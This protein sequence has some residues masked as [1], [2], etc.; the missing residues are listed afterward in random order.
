MDI[1]DAA[2]QQFG[3]ERDTAKRM[4][5]GIL[6]GMQPK[7]LAGHMRWDIDEAKR[8]HSKFLM[9][10][11]PK[12]GEFQGAAKRAFLER[13]YV[14]SVLGRKARLDSSKFAYRAVS[15]IIQNSAGDHLKWMMLKACEFEEAYPDSIQILMTIHD[16]FLWQA[17]MGNVDIVKEVIALM[18]DTAQKP[19]FNFV[20]PI[21]FEVGIGQDWAEAS[22]GQKI[23]DK[24]GWL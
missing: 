10:A 23:K 2:S 11:F 18:E 14:L 13:R 9:E 24:R 3:L 16:S 20:V 22:Y 15:R 5:M 8:A 17:E 12:I 1:H 6:T 4:A 7:A 19:P 21:P